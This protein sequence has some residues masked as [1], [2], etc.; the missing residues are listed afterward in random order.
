MKYTIIIAA[1]MALV[2]AA[3]LL[4][5]G[6]KAIP[7]S[8]IVVLKDGNT[9]DSFQPKFD[10]IAK[11]QNGRGRKPSIHRKYNKISGFAATVNQAALK[12]LLAAPEVAYV[13]QD[14]IF[15]IQD[16]QTSPPSWG[17][18]RVSQTDLDLTQPYLYNE[19]AG[20]GITA[21]VVDTG[22]YAEHEEFEGRATLG[23]NFIDGSEDTDENG[24]GTHVSGTI[25]GAS[26]GIAKKVNIVGVKVLDAS[27]SGS[28][29]G[30]VAGMDWVASQA[31]PGKSVV[32]MS[33]G[34]GKSKAID[35]A[36]ARLFKANIPLIV[37]AGNSA[38]TDACNGSPSGAANA[39]TVAAS[40][41]NDKVASFTSYGKCVEI[42]GPGVGITSSW[43]GSSDAK[44]TISGTSMATPH[45]VGVAALYLSFNSLPTAQSV[46]DKLVATAT[47]NKIT[48]NLK[49]SPNKLVFNGAAA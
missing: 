49:G 5:N 21:Y 39:L 17:L 15:T 11:R 20:E 46:F 8:Y 40:D 7:D 10:D 22:V 1:V 48:G 19:A 28:T 2:Q 34:G 29:S 44:N 31:T 37:A 41:K 9:V 14:Q 18:T 12:E 35:D 26:Y 38:T 45:V 42:F 3:P 33:L 4:N 43:I 16:S 30:V 6:G 36:A 23:A 27:G 13:E 47:P 24:H 25:G 32:N